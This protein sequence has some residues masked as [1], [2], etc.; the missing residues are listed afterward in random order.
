M[1]TLPVEGNLENFASRKTC[2]YEPVDDLLLIFR[3]NVPHMVEK[4][5]SKELRISISANFEYA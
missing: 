2:T 3:S 1:Y 5:Y 4:N